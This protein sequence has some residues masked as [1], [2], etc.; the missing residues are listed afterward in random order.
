M[1]TPDMRRRVEDALDELVSESEAAARPVVFG[2]TPERV[3]AARAAVLAL[4]DA[5]LRGSK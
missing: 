1:M 5:A 4:I 2:G 3:E